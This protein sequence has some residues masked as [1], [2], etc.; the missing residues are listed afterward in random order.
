MKIA[1]ILLWFPK[2]SE[3][4]IFREVQGLRDLG[5]HV[6]VH[7]LYGP[8]VPNLSQEMSEHEIPVTN[9]GV[10]KL[11]RLMPDYAYWAKRKPQAVKGLFR[12]IVLRRWRSFEAFGENLWAFWSGFT[13]AR[14]FEKEGIEH[15]HAPWA[16]GPATAAWVASLLTGIP[17]SFTGR[18][19]DI[20]PPDGS[21]QDK[22]AASLFVRTDVE[23]CIPYLQQHSPENVD[24]VR[25]VYSPVPLVTPG[26]TRAQFSKPLRILA[27]GRF[28]EK[29]GFEYLLRALAELK[30][31]GREVRL[32][33]VGEGGRGPFLKFLTWS[34]GIGNMVNF[35][36]FVSHDEVPPLMAQSDI[37]VMPS[38]EAKCGDRD[39]VPNVVVEAMFHRLPVIGTDVGGLPEAIK[40]GETGYLVE[41][42]NERALVAAIEHM[43]DN[44]E[45]A[46]ATACR[47][48]EFVSNKF[49]IESCQ[50]Q[51][52]ELLLREAKN[53]V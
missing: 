22:I 19:V 24:K 34:L 52:C 49:D 33:L 13:L 5:L 16:T 51:L 9:L 27:M 17:F 25:H 36:G 23:A 41:Q 4:F 3:T 42:K 35:P 40:D 39:G 50:R 30:K 11:G 21:L 46:H 12:K 37:F 6:S 20:Y 44:E 7:T 53:A 47:G 29:K 26:Q 14:R 15:I 18:S 48:Y 31:R 10:K 2:P 38:I 28:V 45:E 43:L 32:T 8:W 1:Y